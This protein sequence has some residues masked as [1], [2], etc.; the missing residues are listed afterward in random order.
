MP[1]WLVPLVLQI[2]LVAVVAWAF[3]TGKVHSDAE[4][5]RREAEHDAELKR[6]H[7]TLTMQINDWRTL[8]QQER[9]DR[10]EA[11]K[12]LAVAVSEI[13]DGTARIEELTKEVIRHGPAR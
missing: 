2:P 11:D 1:E 12:R 7:D 9:T 8:Y 3:V 5:R 10:L 13:R 4:L 6:R